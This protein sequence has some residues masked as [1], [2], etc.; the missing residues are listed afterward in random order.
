ML[1]WIKARKLKLLKIK[2]YE[3]NSSNHRSRTQ[4]ELCIK[5]VMLN[6]ISL[7]DVSPFFTLVL[8]LSKLWSKMMSR[9]HSRPNA[10]VILI[11]LGCICFNFRFLLHSTLRWMF[12]F[13]SWRNTS[14]MIMSRC[15]CFARIF[16]DV[17]VYHKC[18]A[19]LFEVTYLKCTK[20]IVHWSWGIA[21]SCLNTFLRCTFVG[22][23]NSKFNIGP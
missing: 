23:I 7:C 20:S 6:K 16:L 15:L 8:H 19:A 11:Q 2:S 18:L 3:I 9:R 12:A 1:F 10:R 22:F 17:P 14:L 21:I 5:R 4:C 13:L